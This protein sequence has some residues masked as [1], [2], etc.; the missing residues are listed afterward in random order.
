MQT[1]NA[2]M[3]IEEVAQMLGIS[4]AR[5]Y[6]MAANGELPCVRIGR[7]RRVPVR[8]LEAWIEEQVVDAQANSVEPSTSAALGQ[9]GKTR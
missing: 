3:R 6:T 7:S 5:A 8:Q 4:R 1:S 2:L 9:A